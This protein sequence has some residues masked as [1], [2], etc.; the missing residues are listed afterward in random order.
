MSTTRARRLRRVDDVVDRRGRR[1]DAG[2]QDV[3]AEQRVHERR[4]AVVELAE[5]DEVEPLRLELGDPRG[6]DVA[7][8]RDHADGVRD[9]GELREPRDDL[10]LGLLV[11]VEEES[12][13]HADQL[14]DLLVD[15]GQARLAGRVL[16]A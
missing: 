14:G 2:R 13:E 7:R 15:V 10:A 11:M 1:R 9:L 8:E 12:S 6:A 16:T 3:L 5:H 4:L